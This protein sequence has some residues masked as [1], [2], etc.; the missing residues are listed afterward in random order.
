MSRHNRNNPPPGPPSPGMFVGTGPVDV[1][2]MVLEGSRLWYAQFNDMFGNR[3]PGSMKQP[4]IA[5]DVFLTA[6]FLIDTRR[7][8]MGE[9]HYITLVSFQSRDHMAWHLQY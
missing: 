9:S 2:W 1:G 8:S 6:S 7:L 5:S 3:G 4:K